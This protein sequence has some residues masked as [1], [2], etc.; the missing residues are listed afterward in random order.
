MAE[1]DQYARQMKREG[2]VSLATKYYYGI[3]SLPEI[4]KELAFV[5]FLLFYYNQVL[6]LPAGLASLAIMLALIVDAVTDPIVGSLS[7]NLRTKLGRRHPLMYGSAIP[8]GLSLYLLFSP[9]EGLSDLSIFLWLAASA[10]SVRVAI[11][12]F[13]VPWLA[14]F[15]ELTDD[16]EERTTIVKYRYA[17]GYIGG[18][19][20]GFLVWTY[21]FPTTPEYSPGHLN[22]AG[23][24][25]FAI[26]LGLIV[27]AAVLLSTH[28]TRRE[29]PY[30]LQPTGPSS[31]LTPFR[32]LKE[33]WMTLKNKNFRTLFL[34]ILIASAVMGT[35]KSLEIYLYTF[36]WE[37][38]PES[39]RWLAFSALG[40]VIAFAIAGPLQKRF[41]KRNVLIGGYLFI[42][43][44][45]AFLIALRLLNVLPPN[46]SDILLVILVVNSI[47]RIGAAATVIIMFMSMLADVA[48]AIELE[49]TKRQEG[50]VSAGFSFS[51]KV[52]TGVG[53]FFAG[54]ILQYIVAFP[55]NFGTD[56]L[57]DSM[58]VRLGVTVG[59]LVPALYA[60]PILI[61]ARYSLTKEKHSR[62]KNK[63]EEKH[64]VKALSPSMSD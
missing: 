14:F 19:T 50:M 38:A 7:D 46:G 40:A 31:S 60:L 4:L 51:Q 37:L 47:L 63:L 9:P 34:A 32:V 13:Q 55:T 35:Y 10:I 57:D 39:L 36:F 29:I 59:A 16:Y 26:A 28:M 42:A 30:L 17:I 20:F 54:L 11:T 12:F 22:P 53:T 6:H 45:G 5:S 52:T 41:D 48:D 18:A 23:Y 56:G 3:G 43:A 44:D 58:V 49:T 62:I 1:Q 2:P 15:A 33:L 64:K 27:F 61:I 25:K 21:I 8:L 24:E